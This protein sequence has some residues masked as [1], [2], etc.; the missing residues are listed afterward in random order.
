MSKAGAEI[1]EE[2]AERLLGS[3]PKV[4]RLALAAY[5]APMMRSHRGRVH[6]V[7]R[8]GAVVRTTDRREILKGLLSRL[9]IELEVERP[10]RGDCRTCVDCG[11]T[12]RHGAN[13]ARCDVCY[14]QKYLER[15][16]DI[17]ARRYRRQ[18][19]SRCASCARPINPDHST[20][21]PHKP[22][23]CWS[24]YSARQKMSVDEKKAAKSVHCNCGRKLSPQVMRPECV[25]KRKGRP[26]LC[27]LC[28]A[29]FGR[30]ARAQKRAL[31]KA[32]A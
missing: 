7:D 11:A 31:A 30:A 6:L 9:R 13:V 14:V 2:R 4:L 25:E 29:A 16:H 19:R 10:L 5:Y 21:A 27:R 20:R 22:A 8:D 23:E 3:L 28:N 15:R 24:C 12:F 32:A 26:P 18:Q 17:A 1:N